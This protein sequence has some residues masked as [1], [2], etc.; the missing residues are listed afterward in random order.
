[1]KSKYLP[2]SPHRTFGAHLVGSAC[3]ALL[4]ML[5]AAPR[6]AAAATVVSNLGNSTDALYGVI[7]SSGIGLGFER[8]NA[9]TTGSTAMILDSVT[10]DMDVAYDNGGGFKVS[11]YSTITGLPGTDLGVTFTGDTTPDTAGLYT[12]T[13]SAFTLAASTTYWLVASVPQLAPD[14]DYAWNVTNDL[15]Q[16]GDPGW[17]IDANASRFFLSGVPGSWSSN[18]SEAL[19]FSVQASAAAAPEPSR[20]LLL[21]GGVLGVALRRRRGV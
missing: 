4:L 8:A 19:K 2:S 14:K 16:T 9:F 3:A 21:M 13:A 15:S 5:A 20:A 10:L 12:Y 11:L 17:S 7:F 1:M 18:A 6:E